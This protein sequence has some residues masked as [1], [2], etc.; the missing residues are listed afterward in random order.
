MKRFI[1]SALV[2]FFVYNNSFGQDLYNAYKKKDLAK[3]TKKLELKPQLVNSKDPNGCPM[4]LLLARNSSL[5]FI[6]VLLAHGADI[7]TKDIEG[8]TALIYAARNGSHPMLEFLVSQK[9]NVNQVDTTGNT[10]LFYCMD[11][12]EVFDYLLT[13]GVKMDHQ[14]NM[15]RTI[16]MEATG[17]SNKQLSNYLIA[18]GA[19]VNIRDINGETALFNCFS[20]DI[21]A[22]L[23]NKGTIADIANNTNITPLHIAAY[24]GYLDMVELLISNGASLLKK[25]NFGLDALLYA[26]IGENPDIVKYLLDKGADPN[27]KSISGSTPLM[28]AAYKL[29]YMISEQLILKGA[30]IDEQDQDGYAP[31][32]YIFI[33]LEQNSN[34]Y[35]QVKSLIEIFVSKGADINITDKYGNTPLMYATSLGFKNIVEFLIFSGADPG[36]KNNNNQSAVDISTLA[37]YRSTRESLFNTKM[38]DK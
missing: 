38:K 19:D 5:S 26:V 27:S 7:E 14:N 24:R 10:A 30:N 33:D 18:K 31:I 13:N 1:L 12:P 32:F 22:N 25:D 15:G 28:F 4:I 6:K 37:K 23:I 8:K 29:N 35:L 3:F 9:A 21:A 20:S 2:L 36:I 34:Y 11:E 16:L 17:D